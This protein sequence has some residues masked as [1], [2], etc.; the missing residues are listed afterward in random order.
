[1]LLTL[2]A[3][4][5]TP[6]KGLPAGDEPG[7]VDTGPAAEPGDSGTDCPILTLY[8]DGDGDG[9]GDPAVATAGCAGLEGWVVD[10]D[11]CD[12]ADPTIWDTC[13]AHACWMF[14]ERVR[15]RPGADTGGAAASQYWVC[16][17]SMGWQEGRQYCFDFL[18]GDLVALNEDGEIADLQA[19][20]ALIPA[21][22]Y[23][24]GI[25]QPDTAPSVDFGWTWIGAQGT[26]D[27]RSWEEGGVWHVGQPDN[28]GEA[29][30]SSEREEDVGA[31]VES[32]GTWALMDEWIDQDMWPLCEVAI[33]AEDGG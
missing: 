23:W 15:D 27:A 10:G 33:E 13:G 24:V 29:E 30:N 5:C 2:A 9:H 25:S 3:L 17:Q 32:A 14:A 19:A 22:R 26:V 20:S 12:D 7:V 28:G 21:E 6:D 16:E 4:G 1:M 31:W 18:G 8:Y 11:D